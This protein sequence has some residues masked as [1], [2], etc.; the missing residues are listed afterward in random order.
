MSK[1]SLIGCAAIAAFVSF[2]GAASVEAQSLKVKERIAAQEAQLREK[3]GVVNKHCGTNFAVRFD[4]SA[5]P[6]ADLFAY[7][8]SSYC[9]IGALAGILEV[10]GHD[11]GKPAVKEKIK[12]VVCGFGPERAI[13]LKDGVLDYK[14]N[15]SSSNDF[16]FVYEY[17]QN[18]L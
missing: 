9:D 18:N 11:L 5:A 3:A 1:R 16:D 6:Q 12:T 7:S 14:I 13:S 8:P 15:F 4:W 2:G 17:L 10:C